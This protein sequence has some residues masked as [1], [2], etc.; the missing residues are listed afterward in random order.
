M[1]KWYRKLLCHFI[2]LMQKDPDNS[3]SKTVQAEGSLAHSQHCSEVPCALWAGE[4]ADP[5]ALLPPPLPLETRASL[6][7]GVPPL[8][9]L[10]HPPGPSSSVLSLGSGH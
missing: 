9:S 5:C 6:D 3:Q 10:A 8:A 2:T 1:Y 4:G 7:L